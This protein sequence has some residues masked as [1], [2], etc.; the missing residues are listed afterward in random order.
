M[1]GARKGQLGAGGRQLA[2]SLAEALNNKLGGGG[3]LFEL[4]LADL[5]RSTGADNQS[6]ACK[7][8]PAAAAAADT[9]RISCSKRLQKS[10]ELKLETQE[11]ALLVELVRSLVDL[12][13]RLNLKALGLKFDAHLVGV[14]NSI[15]K[16]LE[17]IN[18]SSTQLQATERRLET[19][20]FESLDYTRNL[21]QQFDI[22]NRLNEL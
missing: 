13:D 18:E 10:V 2:A 4:K 6:G 8:A 3:G 21:M 11:L 19:E 16:E 9:L 15:S 12:I 22:A 7:L 20:L 1:D 5:R 17:Q 14:Q